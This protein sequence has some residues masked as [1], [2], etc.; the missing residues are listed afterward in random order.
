M[1]E[2]I[3][4]YETK[5]GRVVNARDLHEYLVK[6]AKGGQE[7]RMFAHWIKERIEAYQF[8]EGQDYVMD[9]YNYQGI[10]LAKKNDTDNQVH[11]REYG[12]TMDMAKELCMI[13]NNDKGRTARKSISTSLFLGQMP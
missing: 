4:I 13:E 12:L 5:N 1:E 11:K 9:E 2:L 6:D 7:G 8:I 10:R 3:K